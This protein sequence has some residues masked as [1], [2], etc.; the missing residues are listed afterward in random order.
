MEEKEFWKGKELFWRVKI[1]MKK[2]LEK[3]R[4]L[5]WYAWIVFFF[6]NLKEFFWWMKYKIQRDENSWGGTTANCY[7]KKYK[8]MGFSRG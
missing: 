8:Q 4:L 6:F 2:F 7:K 3:M 5:M 1:G